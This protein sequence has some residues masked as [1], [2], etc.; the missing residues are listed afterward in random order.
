MSSCEVYQTLYGTKKPELEEIKG[1]VY[2]VEGAQ[3]KEPNILAKQVYA[4][5][6]PIEHDP[7]KLGK[8]PLGPFDKGKALGFTLEQWLS[9]TGDGT[10][11]FDG[12][13]AEL[14]LSFK[15]LVSSGVYTVWCSRLTFPPNAQIVD[16]P[17]GADD[18]SENSFT[19]DAKGNDIFKLK[20]KTLELSTKETAT[21]IAIAYHSDG[22]TYGASPGDF[23][24]NSHV[25]LF[26]LLPELN[27]SQEKGTTEINFI[28]H[29]DANMPEQDVFVELEEKIEKPEAIEEKEERKP[30]VPEV[31]GEVTK[32]EQVPEEIIKAKEK[33][34]VI[35]VQ[36]TE[37]VSLVPKA[38]DPDKDT[39]L[40]FTFTSPLNENGEWQTAYGDA[41]EYTI[42]ITATDGELTTKRDVLIIVNKKEE[43]PTIDSTKPIETGLI[44]DETQSITFDVEASDLNKDPLSYNWKL[45]GIDIS[46]DK[47]FTYKT[48]YDDAGT[49]TVKVDVTDSISATSKIWSVEV[50]NVNRKPMLED[51]QNIEVKETD[52][53]TITA[54][55]TDDD[56][57]A[58]TYSINDN[59]FE[60]ED[61]IFTWQTDYDSAGT[62][63]L[64]I[65]TSDAQ[66]TTEQTFTVTVENVNRAPLITDVIQKK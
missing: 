65:T 61:N 37:L 56:K 30:E 19:A 39:S 36:E 62:Y 59:R 34:I 60:Q 23:G 53:I 38:E 31:I 11:S 57:D 25:Q 3:A 5:A 32:E 24:L 33:P 28:D 18:G 48:T 12:N 40:V 20:L 26:Y 42:T 8:N 35:V 10:Y 13:F 9:A 27:E 2:R 29:I 43:P 21:V 16:K 58:I 51:I 49:H 6:K 44:I 55:A 4:S 47:E 1:M 46:K 17:C 50:K 45:D 64:V 54:L 22:K 7:F 63:Q 66:D 52:K 15:N 14:E 41:G